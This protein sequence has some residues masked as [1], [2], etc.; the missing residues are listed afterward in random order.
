MRVVATQ[1]GLTRLRQD[2]WQVDLNTF[3]TDARDG[4]RLTEEGFEL[5][6]ELAAS[7]NNAGLQQWGES[8]QGRPILALWIGQPPE[9]GAPSVRIAGAH[10]GD[11]SSSYEVALSVAE[12]LLS[13]PPG[14]TAIADLLASTTVWVIPYVNPYGVADFTRQNA[15]G[16]DLNRN[17]G[18]E[19]SAQAF[20]AGDA[21]F[22]EP[23]VQ[24]IRDSALLTVPYTS[25][26]LHSGATNIGYP[27]NYTFDDTA[28]EQLMQELCDVYADEV[29]NPSFYVTNGADWYPTTGDTNDWSYGT[30]GGMDYTVELTA[31]KTPPLRVLTEQVQDHTGAVLQWLAQAPDVVGTVRDADTGE[32]IAARLVVTNG[33]SDTSV[34]FYANALSGQFARYLAVDDAVL[35]ISAP[36]YASVSQDI[37]GQQQGIIEDRKSVV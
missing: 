18:F 16:V 28:E 9:F 29:D 15:V 7:D 3:G 37:I 12:T 24:A 14:N 31:A 33:R 17:Y 6:E 35:R 8:H 20:Q 23:E 10:H 22:S 25:L 27:Y 1:A 21:P 36:G 13:S 5:M 32:P 34:P 2:G 19:W 11:E 30:Y 4:Y 26:S